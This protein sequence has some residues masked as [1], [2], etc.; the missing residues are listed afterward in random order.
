MRNP[1]AVV[2]RVRAVRYLSRVT[3]TV[4]RRWWKR[5]PDVPQVQIVGVVDE[6][7]RIVADSTGT[8]RGQPAVEH[9]VG[10]GGGADQRSRTSPRFSIVR[11]TQA[12]A[13]AHPFRIGGRGT[14][15]AL[16]VFDRD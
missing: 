6:S 1:V 11:T 9:I 8:L 16:Q 13:S 3:E 12:V 4:C 15:W 7:G 10:S 5:F 14:G 2:S